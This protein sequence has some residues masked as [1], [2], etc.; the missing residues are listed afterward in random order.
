MKE[1]KKLAKSVSSAYM[2]NH[3]FKAMLMTNNMKLCIHL[4]IIFIIIV[5]ASTYSQNNPGAARIMAREIVS[6]SII[7]IFALYIVIHTY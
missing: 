4:I 1:V 2:F 5:I 6:P 3:H 7:N